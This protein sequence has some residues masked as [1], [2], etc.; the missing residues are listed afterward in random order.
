MTPKQHPTKIMKHPSILQLIQQ[1]NN[2]KTTYHPTTNKNPPNPLSPQPPQ[3][4]RA[5]PLDN[6]AML[7]GVDSEFGLGAMAPAETATA[8]GG[9]RITSWRGKK[10]RFGCRLP[11]SKLTNCYGK[12]SYFQVHTIK[13]V[14]LFFSIA[15]LVYPECSWCVWKLVG[16]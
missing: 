13:N 11:S 2:N 6:V 4:P 9:N 5:F 8:V 3:P 7:Q 14:W 12:S 16:I 15:I 10:I 1:K